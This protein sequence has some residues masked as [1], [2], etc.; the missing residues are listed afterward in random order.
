MS[1]QWDRQRTNLQPPPLR[2]PS[3]PPA[4]EHTAT[5]SLTKRE[6]TAPHRTAPHRTAPHVV[7]PALLWILSAYFQMWQ[8]RG[9]LK[10][11]AD[12]NGGLH[13]TSGHW[14]PV[15]PHSNLPLDPCTKGLFAIAAPSMG[16]CT[17]PN[18]LGC[19][20]RHSALW[21]YTHLWVFRREGPCRKVSLTGAASAPS[22]SFRAGPAMLHVQ[23]SFIRGGGTFWTRPTHPTLDPPRPPP[24]L[25]ILWGAFFVNQIEAKALSRF[26]H[27]Q[28]LELQLSSLT[29][30]L[31]TSSDSDVQQRV[32]R[33]NMLSKKRPC[34]KLPPAHLPPA[35]RHNRK[36]HQQTARQ[37]SCDQRKKVW[38]EPNP[39]N[40]QNYKRGG[41]PEL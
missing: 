16:M 3:P 27:P 17:C 36:G 5:Q 37:G 34:E 2:P 14:V 21:V 25:I 10:G 6:T 38:Q 4:P 7:F 23:A 8:R 31:P 41:G 35:Q 32:H 20:T 40:P 9:G 39:G 22:G 1:Q 26:R 28:R 29:T 24:P 13:S 30:G 12:N 11:L 33:F 15:V 18:F 19:V